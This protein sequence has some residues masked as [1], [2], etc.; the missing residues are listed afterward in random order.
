MGTVQLVSCLTHGLNFLV[1]FLDAVIG[2]Q[3]YLLLHGL[4]FMLFAVVYVLW[5][6]IHYALGIGNGLGDQYIYE[7]L[8]WDATASTASLG[9]LIVF[10]AAPI[11]NFIFWICVNLFRNPP[12]NHKVKQLADDNGLP[13]GNAA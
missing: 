10:V 9:L 3:P 12:S 5:S 13:I 2:S 1:M 6:L 8:D 7:A 11:V 4:Y